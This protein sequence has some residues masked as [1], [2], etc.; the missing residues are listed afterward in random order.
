VASLG[1]AFGLRWSCSANPAQ[2][3][4]ALQRIEARWKSRCPQRRAARLLRGPGAEIIDLSIMSQKQIVD[5]LQRVANP[6][7]AGGEA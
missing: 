7:E 3:D 5:D 6:A 1:E 2:A 4:E